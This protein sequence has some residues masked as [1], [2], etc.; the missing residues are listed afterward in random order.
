MIN[1]WKIGATG[2]AA[3]WA[4]AAV[5]ATPA[6]QSAVSARK[7]NYKE[8]GATF[9]A[10]NDEI[11]SGSPDMNTVRPLARTLAARASRSAQ[12]FVPGSGPS[13]GLPTRAKALIWTEQANFGRIQQQ[14][15]SAANALNVSAAAGNVAG[16]TAARNALG[17]TCKSCHD[18][19][20]E[21]S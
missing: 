10:I 1:N 17:A 3:V 11:R 12:H 5:A 13:S 16:L 18:R 14:M 8:I 15:I 20:R 9:K 7:A 2:L 6:Q 19:Y 21:E 4:F